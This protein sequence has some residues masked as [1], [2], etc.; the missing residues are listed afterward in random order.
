MAPCPGIL[1]PLQSPASVLGVLE[2]L[3]SFWA[4]PQ[5]CLSS[6][7]LNCT[8]PIGPQPFLELET[9]LPPSIICSVGSKGGPKSGMLELQSIKEINKPVFF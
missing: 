7:S 1:A 2:V 3:D 5:G 4:V 8:I 6:C 9:L